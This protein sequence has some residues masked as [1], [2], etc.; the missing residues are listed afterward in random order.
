MTNKYKN[1][2]SFEEIMFENLD[3]PEAIREYLNASL[4][5]YLDEGDIN[6]FCNALEYVVKARKNLSAFAKDINIS[7]AGLYKALNSGSEPK[8]RTVSKILKKLGY[9][10]RIA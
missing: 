3:S 5:L 7:R 6:S 2:V 10:L 4:E 8:M 9:S 1:T